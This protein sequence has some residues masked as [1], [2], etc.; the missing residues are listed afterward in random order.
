MITPAFYPQIGGK[1]NYVLR[2]HL[3]LNRLVVLL[4]VADNAAPKF[5]R[6]IVRLLPVEVFYFSTSHKLYLMN[7]KYVL[8]VVPAKRNMYVID[9][10]ISSNYP[11][12]FTFYAQLV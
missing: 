8:C 10:I 2:S 9:N 1:E 3:C 4:L 7:R 11:S 12:S 5:Q 6:R